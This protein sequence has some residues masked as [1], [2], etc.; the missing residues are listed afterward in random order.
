M[1]VEPSR[2]ISLSLSN[3]HIQPETHTGFGIFLNA[4]GGPPPHDDDDVDLPEDDEDWGDQEEQ[5]EEEDL[6]HDPEVDPEA[7]PFALTKSSH[8]QKIVT[9]KQILNIK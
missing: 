8:L 1:P 3:T 7:G 9:Y 6:E 2:C 4:G 5:P